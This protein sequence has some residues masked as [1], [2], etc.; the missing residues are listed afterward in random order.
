MFL[1]TKRK[2]N[3]SLFHV[4]GC[5]SQANVVS[6]NPMMAEVLSSPEIITT[7]CDLRIT[8]AILEDKST[9]KEFSSKFEHLE[10][11]DPNSVLALKRLHDN[12]NA[13]MDG[14]GREND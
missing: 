6:E 12:I 5:H 3:N 11:L 9:L 4:F 8:A 10:S 13:M 14:E 2:V 1:T 7:L